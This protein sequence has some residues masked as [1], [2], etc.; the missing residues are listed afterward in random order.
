MN[1]MYPINEVVLNASLNLFSKVS[2]IIGVLVSVLFTIRI[3]FLLLKSAGG[4]EYGA[5]VQ[6]TGKYLVLVSLF[7]MIVRFILDASGGLATSLAFIP[8]DVANSQIENFFSNLFGDYAILRVFSSIGAAAVV[9][10]SQS[11]YS[12]FL[13]VLLAIAPVVILFSTMLGF[14]QGIGP[15]IM[16]LLS[17]CMWPVLWNLLGR[18]GMELWPF[19]ATSPLSTAC[20]WFLLLV[21]QLLSPLFSIFLFI[22]L[23][24]AQSVAKAVTMVGKGATFKK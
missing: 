1:P 23:S 6:D 2:L 16:S 19:F 18:L 24:P 13:A 21:V 12:L 5:L 4:E 14:S 3:T 10:I 11:A 9:I 17:L 8:S 7:P 20:F 15:Y 22:S